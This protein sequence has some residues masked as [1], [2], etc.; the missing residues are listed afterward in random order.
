MVALLNNLSQFTA[1]RI[2]GE[3][4]SKRSPDE[5]LPQALVGSNGEGFTCR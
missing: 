5:G 1:F 4:V 3:G 2:G